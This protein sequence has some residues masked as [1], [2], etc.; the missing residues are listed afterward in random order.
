MRAMITRYS[1]LLR[2]SS[3][4]MSIIWSDKFMT[5]PT[6]KGDDW[7]LFPSAERVNILKAM[8]SPTAGKDVSGGQL[9]ISNHFWQTFL[10]L[11]SVFFTQL[12]FLIPFSELWKVVCFRSCGK[13]EAS[14]ASPF[15]L[16]EALGN[17]FR[18]LCF[19]IFLFDCT[20]SDSSAG[21][22]WA[23]DNHLL[24][25]IIGENRSTGS[26]ASRGGLFFL[27]FDV[28]VGVDDFWA[29]ITCGFCLIEVVAFLNACR[30]GTL[31][32][33]VTK[34]SGW[35]SAS[36]LDFCSVWG[37][38]LCSRLVSFASTSCL[39]CLLATLL[40]VGSV[41]ILTLVEIGLTSTSLWRSVNFLFREL[42]SPEIGPNLW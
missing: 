32:E 26:V 14:F 30:M 27:G 38:V 24:M 12:S 29:V 39:T 36:K 7:K 1:L 28:S 42:L 13:L 11:F 18:A 40:G 3:S 21:F 10:S 31:R 15:L 17:V 34:S 6:L 16:L 19:L 5:D 20:D 4:R 33:D 2:T 25:M 22:F 35:G 23:S 9:S 8:I 37:S 41:L